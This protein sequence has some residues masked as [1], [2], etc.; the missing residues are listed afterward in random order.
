ML[1]EPK[2]DQDRNVAA[3][4]D[5]ADEPDE[6]QPTTGALGAIIPTGMQ[7]GGDENEEQG[8]CGHAAMIGI[9]TRPLDKGH[10]ETPGVWRSRLAGI[11]LWWGDLSMAFG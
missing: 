4:D 3:A 7:H 9:L 8:E 6:R 10:G 1:P 11:A 5:R 2:D